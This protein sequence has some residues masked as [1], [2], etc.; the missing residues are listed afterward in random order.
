VIWSRKKPLLTSRAD[1]TTATP[2]RF[3]EQLVSHLGHRIA[4]ER[5]PDGD[6]YTFDGGRGAV[7]VGDGVLVLL[8]T[9]RG[10]EALGTVQDVLG[11]HLE[12]FGAQQQLVVTWTPAQPAELPDPS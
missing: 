3:A 8:A 11:R 5:T 9:A 1:V 2:A 10:E 12:R 7:S 4:I 6:V